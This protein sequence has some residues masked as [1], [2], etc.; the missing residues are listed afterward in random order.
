MNIQSVVQ[1]L[2]G[3]VAAALPSS[4]AVRSAGGDGAG[5]PPVAIIEWNA[6]RLDVNGANPY[7]GVERDQSGTATARE[8]HRYYR[9]EGVVVVRAQSEADRDTWLDD[10][11][12]RFVLYED[13]ADGFHAD[14][15]EWEVGDASPR[16]VQVVEPDWY[17]GELELT[18]R[19]VKRTTDSADALGTISDGANGGVY[20]D[21]SL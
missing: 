7:A 1:G 12:D 6:H 17:E 5:G 15:F 16:S 4:V 11:G 10:L 19:F 18:F 13:D 9:L 2:V 3:E 14:T 20:V 21:D 8:L